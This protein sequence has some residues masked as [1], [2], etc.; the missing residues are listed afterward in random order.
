LHLKNKLELTILA[1]SVYFLS[2]EIYRIGRNVRKYLSRPASLLD[3]LPQIL[4][5][6]NICQKYNNE[7]DEITPRFW[8]IQ[9]ITALL[10][11]FK[12]LY[13]LRSNAS[14]SY[15]VRMLS[16]VCLAI[17]PFL[18]ILTVMVFAFADAGYSLSSSL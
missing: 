7:E 9:A 8:R 1:L 13:F 10:L 18:V 2:L 16:E 3:A 12:M 4:L 11:W 17:Y 5:I 14:T 6:I 15:F